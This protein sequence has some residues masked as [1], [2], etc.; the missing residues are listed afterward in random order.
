MGLTQEKYYER[1]I[2]LCVF[3]TNQINTFPEN[4]IDQE[5]QWPRVIADVYML[6][7]RPVDNEMLKNAIML[8][9]DVTSGNLTNTL[10]APEGKTIH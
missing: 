3:M 6:Y 5:V 7:D 1:I 10:T 9:Q 2:D 8:I 4:I